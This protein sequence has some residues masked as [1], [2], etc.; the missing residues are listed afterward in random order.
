MASP[1][2]QSDWR[3][4]PHRALP[5]SPLAMAMA[6]WRHRGLIAQMVRREVVGRYKGSIMGLAWS[7]L[8][9]L[10]MLAIYTFVFSVIFKARWGTQGDE[11]KIN[12]AIVLFVGLIVHGLFAECVNRAPGLIVGNANYVKRVVFPLDI[13]PIVALGSALF[14][15]A[16]STVVLL[17]AMLVAGNPLHWTLLLWP[18]LMLPIAIAALGFGWFLAS[19]G[20]FLRDVG[21][22]TLIF[23]TALLF[24]SPVFFPVSAM[25]EQ[26]RAVMKVNPLTIAIEQ[27]RGAMIWGQ[28]PDWGQYAA[29]LGASLLLAWAGFWWFQKTRK[30]FADVI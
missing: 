28:T 27:M 16:V 26:Y 5:A 12:F 21:Q 4:D 30:G 10:L 8:N 1:N 24:L 25:P 13:L 11:S 2:V 19:L 9:P 7:F 29:Y 14:H 18:V 23:T 3:R 20:V 6:P 17:V 15:A 22:I